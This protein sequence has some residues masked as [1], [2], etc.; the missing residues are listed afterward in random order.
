MRR[1]P[2]HRAGASAGMAA[3]A[4]AP[5]ARRWAPTL[6]AALLIGG[7][8][9]ATA[10][11]AVDQ[12]RSSLEQEQ[13]ARAETLAE[14]NASLVSG[15]IAGL[16]Q[17][18]R[19]ITGSELVQVYAAGAAA[20][21]ELAG[22]LV[23][24]GPFLEQLFE[25]FVLQH[26]LI[27]ASL[28]APNGDVLLTV[29]ELPEGPALPEDA[30]MRQELLVSPLYELVGDAARRGVRAFD[31]ILP[32]AAVS[33]LIPPAEGSALLVMTSPAGPRLAGVLRGDPG[34]D[35]A[36]RPVL[37]QETGADL[38]LSLGDEMGRPA[39]AA[40]ARGIDGIVRA[41][42]SGTPWVIEQPV[43]PV[44]EGDPV[45]VEYRRRAFAVAT[46]VVLVLTLGFAC[47]QQAVS[48]GRR[49]D[50]PDAG[51]S[52]AEQARAFGLMFESLAGAVSDGIGLKDADGRYLYANA[53]LGERFGRSADA[54]VGRTD[55]ELLDRGSPTGSASGEGRGGLPAIVETR[56]LERDLD[57]SG[58]ALVVAP[59]GA[60]RSAAPA[61]AEGMLP[62]VLAG[63]LTVDQTVGLLTRAV[64]LR[65]PF[66]R[67]H[68]ERLAELA[69]AVARRLE[70]PEAERATIELAGRLSQVG[71]IFIPDAVL[72]KPGR[73]DEDEART[74]R[75]HVTRALDL[76]ERIEFGL[77][78]TFALGQMHERLDGGGYPLGLAGEEIGLAGRILGA[79]D[80]FCARTAPRAYRDQISVGQALFYLAGHPERYDA[81][82]VTALVAVVTEARQRPGVL[83]PPKV[84]Q[85]EAPAAHA[86]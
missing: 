28:V 46:G 4:G 66:L 11:L 84:V 56:H 61:R 36:S 77:P 29:G 5:R 68:A 52:E 57:L 63:H 65:D 53:A 54:I 6:G 15:Y 13:R 37:A 76:L 26:D 38:R 42:V 20:E 3:G 49:R 79:V 7:V 12:R 23:D 73:H 55:A 22:W 62:A 51:A 78:V 34:R 21:S 86:A 80:V 67:G 83:P 9:Y 71:K 35:G 30:G 60:A 47:Y 72:T 8:A 19:R 32:V 14:A 17:V 69:G 2:P 64:E 45:L 33:E 40:G 85:E 16:A 59:S 18:A 82:V 43:A 58:L 1:E 24:Q 74:M 81:R 25:D 39:A 27:A 48:R 75:S 44:D 10:Q 31:V 41:P 70:L 50:R